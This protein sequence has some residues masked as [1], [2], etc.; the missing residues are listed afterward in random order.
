MTPRTIRNTVALAVAIATLGTGV[1]VAITQLTAPAPAEA[2]AATD[3][4][5]L[6]ELRKISASLASVQ[7]N[8][9]STSSR[10][11]LLGLLDDINNALGGA[12]TVIERP[13]ARDL[14]QAI[15]RHTQ[16]AAENYAAC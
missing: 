4:A 16:G 7:A 3:R 12:G 2:T 1:T 10:G 8:V 6:R 13:T 9:G 14:L 5:M 11:S 15:C